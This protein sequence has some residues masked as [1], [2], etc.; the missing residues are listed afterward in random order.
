MGLEQHISH[1]PSCN[2]MNSTGWDEAREALSYCP[3]GPDTDA[4]WKEL[5]E[6]QKICTCGLEKSYKSL[7]LSWYKKGWEDASEPGSNE[8]IEQIFERQYS[9][10]MPKFGT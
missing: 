6:K 2:R 5:E 4:A 10:L 9:D 1:L 8:A 7:I 3:P